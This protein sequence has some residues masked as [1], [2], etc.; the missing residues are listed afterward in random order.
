[1]GK[2]SER[3]VVIEPHPV[4]GEVD[5]GQ[6]LQVVSDFIGTL[7]AVGGKL[8]IAADRV[9]V[10]KVQVGEGAVEVGETQGLVLRYQSFSPAR[11][12]DEPAPPL[13]A[14]PPETLRDEIEAEVDAAF[15]TDDDGG[16]DL[17]VDVDVDPRAAAPDR[18]DLLSEDEIRELQ[19]REAAAHA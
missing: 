10:G 13:E 11:R 9:I 17:T 8:Q 14:H 16:E 19:A 6:V 18:D 4:T 1:V 12:S 5:R 2:P 15:E 7:F 3:I